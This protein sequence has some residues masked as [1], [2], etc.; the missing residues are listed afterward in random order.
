MMP[1][2]RK[3]LAAK[4][5]SMLITSSLTATVQVQVQVQVQVVETRSSSHLVQVSFTRKASI[6][7]ESILY[8]HVA[9][10]STSNISRFNFLKY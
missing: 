7:L 8:I 1:S 2:S 3:I 10:L 9:L 5:G 6:H 4:E